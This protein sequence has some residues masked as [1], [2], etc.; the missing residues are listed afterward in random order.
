MVQVN[1]KFDFSD[2]E[3]HKIKEF[4]EALAP[5]E[6][7]VD[8]LCIE[9]SDLLLAEKVVVFIPK[10]LRDQN[11]EARKILLKKFEARVEERLTSAENEPF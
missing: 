9:D 7:A 10:K 8:C 3:S 4:C 2:A 6:I 5:I 1:R 11:I